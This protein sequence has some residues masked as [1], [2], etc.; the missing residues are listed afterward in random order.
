MNGTGNGRFDPTGRLTREQVAQIIK[1]G[2]KLFLPILKLEKKIGT[3]EQII[4]S[5]DSSFG[6]KM[7]THTFN[8]R[9]IN[10]KL[11]KLDARFLT[12]AVDKN[13]NELTGGRLYK[14]RDGFY[15]LQE[16]E[17]R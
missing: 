14:Y 16:R 11:H 3:I 9:N 12:D 17:D 4:K 1:N 7:T 10:G 8:I 5:T 15:S 6:E 13:K 2:E